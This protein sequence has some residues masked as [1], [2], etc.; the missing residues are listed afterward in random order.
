[1]AVTLG[2]DSV[3]SEPKGMAIIVS[4]LPRTIVRLF[5]VAIIITDAVD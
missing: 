5:L 1:M 3:R 2:A 4:P